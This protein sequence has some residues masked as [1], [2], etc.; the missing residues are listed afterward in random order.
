MIEVD[1]KKVFKDN[2]QLYTVDY[3]HINGLWKTFGIYESIDVAFAVHDL[4]KTGFISV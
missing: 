3:R 2:K 4:I 1:I